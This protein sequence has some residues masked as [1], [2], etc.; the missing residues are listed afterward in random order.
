MCAMHHTLA[1]STKKWQEHC[2]QNIMAATNIK[3]DLLYIYFI[4]TSVPDPSLDP[5]PYPAGFLVAFKNARN[6]YR[7]NSNRRKGT[8]RH[9]IDMARLFRSPIPEGSVSPT[10]TSPSMS[11]LVLDI[12]ISLL[13][14]YYAFWLLVRTVTYES[15]AQFYPSGYH[16]TVP[17]TTAR[18]SD[19]ASMADHHFQT[20][21]TLGEGGGGS[22]E[23]VFYLS[24]WFLPAFL[25]LRLRGGG[26]STLW[27]RRSLHPLP[28]KTTER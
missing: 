22:E 1:F 2:C 26:V 11:G 4:N 15:K 7:V 6:A 3:I 19:R 27:I 12:P 18:W 20:L 8:A 23:G 24:K 10:A 13:Y 17:A 28:S 5:D 9:I 16:L 14:S 25:E 21:P